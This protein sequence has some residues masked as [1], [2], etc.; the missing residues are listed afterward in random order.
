MSISTRFFVGLENDQEVSIYPQFIWGGRGRLLLA[1]VSGLIVEITCLFLVIRGHYDF[2]VWGGLI[3]GSLILFM[4]VLQ[5]IWGAILTINEQTFSLRPNPFEK[6][7]DI[8]W[9]EIAAICVS[10]NRR[11]SLEIIPSTTHTEAFLL[12]QTPSLRK[13][14]TRQLEQTG[15]IAC[16]PRWPSYTEFLPISLFYLIQNRYQQQIQQYHIELRDERG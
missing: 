9:E 8:Q 6:R 15:C 16:F 5:R 7:I 13:S 2:S 10:G 12:R 4:I 11:L 14:L 1:L 3:V